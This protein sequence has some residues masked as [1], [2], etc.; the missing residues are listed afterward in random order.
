MHNIKYY[1][2]VIITLTSCKDKIQVALQN[3]EQP[4]VIEGLLTNEPIQS[5]D[6]HRSGDFYEL[7]AYEAINDATVQIKDSTGLTILLTLDQNGH[8]ES[9]AW[10]AQIGQEY[11][12]T[13]QHKEETYTAKTILPKQIK[14][15]EVDVKIN[16]DSSAYIRCKFE[17]PIGEQNF[18]RLRFYRNGDIQESRLYVLRDLNFEG[19]TK[20]YNFKREAIAYGDTIVVELWH[21]PKHTYTYYS[22]LKEVIEQGLL[23]SVPYNPESNIK[24]GA[25]GYWGAAS[26]DRDTLILKL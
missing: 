15:K 2:F 4:I 24:G 20:I 26:I 7:D 16:N 13:I 21:I 22:Q 17:D 12:L 8:Y 23:S 1:I 5:I 14:I 25:L 19:K 10:T 3:D 11:N 6:I 18:Y 9:V